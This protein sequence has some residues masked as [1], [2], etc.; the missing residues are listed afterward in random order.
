MYSNYET[1]VLVESILDLAK[2]DFVAAIWE[3]SW[4]IGRI[5]HLSVIN[6]EAQIN[7]MHS[8]GN[9]RLQYRWPNDPDEMSIKTVDVLCKLKIPLV[10]KRERKQISRF[11]LED[12]CLDEIETVFLSRICRKQLAMSAY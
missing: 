4:W 3:K 9:S 7:F 5:E 12:K 8:I 2:N 6:D 1:V 11:E 10:A